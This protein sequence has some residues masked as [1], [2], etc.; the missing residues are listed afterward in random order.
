MTI[1]EPDAEEESDFI[2]N[3]MPTWLSLLKDQYVIKGDNLLY[4]MGLNVNMFGQ[5]TRVSIEHSSEA[6]NFVFYEA[7]NNAFIVIGNQVTDLDVKTWPISVI[8]EYVDPTGRY[9]RFKNSFKLMI[10]SDQPR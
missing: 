7:D 5:S 6:L 8:S 3:I 1:T 2:L 4:P 10:L 9:H